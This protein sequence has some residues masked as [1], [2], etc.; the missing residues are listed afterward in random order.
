MF[1]ILVEMARGDRVE[2]KKVKDKVSEREDLLWQE[3]SLPAVA[4]RINSSLMTSWLGESGST[5][6]ISLLFF[7]MAP[8]RKRQWMN[9]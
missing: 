9:L 8:S 2:G 4:R 7:C 5:H 3:N 1:S 6:P